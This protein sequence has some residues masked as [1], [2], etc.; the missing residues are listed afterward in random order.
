MGSNATLSKL[1][2]IGVVGEF[3]PKL[4]ILNINAPSDSSLS[5]TVI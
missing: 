5:V 1:P 3:E 2:E 4:A